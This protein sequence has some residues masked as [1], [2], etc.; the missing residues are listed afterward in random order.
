M[1]LPLVAAIVLL[2]DRPFVYGLLCLVVFGLLFEWA[3]LARIMSNL[4]KF[5]YATSGTAVA[6]A[7][8][9]LG[10]VAILVTVI[11]ALCV[12]VPAFFAVLFFRYA[13]VVLSNRAL[14]AVLGW[15]VCIGAMVSCGFLNGD[16]FTLI[17]VLVVVWLVDT[18]AYFAGTYF[19]SHKLNKTL[20]PNKT[21]EGVLGGIILGLA[22]CLIVDL[23][24]G[25]LPIAKLEAWIGIAALAVLGDLFES[26]LKR[27]A[28]VKDSGDLL[29]G[30]GGLLDRLDSALFAAPFVFLILM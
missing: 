14:V 20:S 9:L 18:G 11:C 8:P 26:A 25:W 12:V 15:I 22:T 16:G 1:L 17:S 2:A 3:S 27:V 6:V 23:Y 10:D 13:S 29:P 19:G 30:H 21:W 5:G 28:N 7:I 24:L 4:S